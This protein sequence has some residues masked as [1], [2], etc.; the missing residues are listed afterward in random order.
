MQPQRALLLDKNYVALSIVTL[1][2]AIKLMVNGK[3]EP[4]CD[5]RVVTKV[6]HC[7][8]QFIVPSVLR[9]LTTVPW[10]AHMGH[11]RF[12]RRNVIVR[13]NNE[14]QYCGKKVTKNATID[15][16][17]PVSR[18]GKSEYTN[19]VTSCH[20]CNNNKANKTPS[21]AGLKLKHKPKNPSFLTA[22]RTFL[23][24]PPDEWKI[25]IMGLS[26]GDDENNV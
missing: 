26:G 20:D 9:L 15:H 14:C 4:V 13:D 6:Q 19:C 11:S 10:K 23:D 21:E 25:Y 7:N 1:R 17:I 5:V 12:S 2:K 16:V 22:N 8:G 3:A 18:G 24:N